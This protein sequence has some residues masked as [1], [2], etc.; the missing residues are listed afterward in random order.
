MEFKETIETIKKIGFD[1]IRVES[2]DYFEAVILRQKLPL[3]VE[4]LQKIFGKSICPPVNELAKDVGEIV[5]DF[6]GIRG[7]QTLYF[8]KDR[9]IA[10]FVMLWP[11]S[12]EY[13]VTVKM[14]RR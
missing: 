14:G 4:E 8:L 12:D 11:W 3:L 5:E 2:P 6:G 10:Y 7:D 1:V 9:D 13:H